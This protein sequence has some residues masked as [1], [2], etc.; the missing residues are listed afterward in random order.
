MT[1][2][3]KNGNVVF[4]ENDSPQTVESLKNALANAGDAPLLGLVLKV[5]TDPKGEDQVVNWMFADTSFI[6]SLALVL[7]GKV[8]RMK[9]K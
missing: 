7:P 4:F 3:A 1:Q 5:E 9:D 6:K 2:A 8:K